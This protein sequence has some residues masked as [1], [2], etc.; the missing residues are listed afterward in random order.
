MVEG[1][2]NLTSTFRLDARAVSGKVPISWGER[3]GSPLSPFLFVVV[4]NMVSVEPTAKWNKKGWGFKLDLDSL[5]SHLAF[6]DDLILVAEDPITLA[7]MAAD[8]AEELARVGLGLN[9]AGPALRKTE[10]CSVSSGMPFRTPPR[11]RDCT[12][13]GVS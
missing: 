1:Y 2:K 11:A 10:A 7:L 6:A 5:I 8:V 9:L 12:T 3:Q 13:W 4:L